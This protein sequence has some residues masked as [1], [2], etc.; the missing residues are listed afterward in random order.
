MLAIEDKLVSLDLIEENFVCDLNACKGACCV[1]GDYGAPLEES[2]LKILDDIYDTVKP[3]ISEEGQQVVADGGKHIYVEEAGKHSTPLRSDGVCV[4][5]YFDNGGVAKCGIEKAW[6]EGKVAFQKPVSCQLY[7]IRVTRYANYEAVN[8]ERW[9]ICKAACK[10][11]N[12]LK[13]PVY[14]FLKDGLVR[15]F[16]ID[17]YEALDAYAQEVKK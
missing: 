2:E 8:Y 14:K 15:K 4:Y 16:G 10:N 1:Q 5:T 11:G 9:S 7:P 6:I 12:K 13:V 3:Y 17:F